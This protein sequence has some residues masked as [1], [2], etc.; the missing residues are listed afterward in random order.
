MPQTQENQHQFFP[1]AAGSV[2]PQTRVCATALRGENSRLGPSSL[3]PG[4]HRGFAIANSTTALGLRA[5]WAEN[6]G[7]AY[8]CARY[9]NPRMGRFISE[10]P[11]GF[12]GGINKYTY[13]AD[14]PMDFKDPF[15]KDKTPP[16]DPCQDGQSSM[17]NPLGSAVADLG[18]AAAARLHNTPLGLASSAVSVGSDPTVPNILLN[19]ESNLIPLVVEGSDLP[20]A[21]GFAAWDG[22]QF[23][24]NAL[25][26]V[27]TPCGQAQSETIPVNG[28][29]MP[30]PQAVF[31]AGG[32]VN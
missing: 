11:I 2:W 28:I 4:S 23:A 16:P 22:S 20:I 19:A 24:G 13:V 14:S 6:R 15:G 29:N 9:Y 27:F 12:R 32:G 10:D 1:F 7:G 25:S 17:P 30:D 18:G 21:Y 26:T 3:N 31:D 8:R 5:G